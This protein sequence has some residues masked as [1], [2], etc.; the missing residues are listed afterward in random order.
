L[1]FQS[2]PLG[3]YSR[4]IPLRYLHHIPL[5]FVLSFQPDFALADCQFSGPSPSIS[6]APQGFFFKIPLF[7]P[8]NSL[9]QFSIPCPFGP[10]FYTPPRPFF[11]F[12][13]Q[14]CSY[15]PFCSPSAQA[16]VPLWRPLSTD[17]CPPFDK[18]RPLD[19]LPAWL[20]P[21]SIWEKRPVALLPVGPR[22][23][24]SFTTFSPTPRIRHYKTFFSQ[25]EWGVYASFHVLNRPFPFPFFLKLPPPTPFLIQTIVFRCECETLV[26]FFFFPLALPL[27][28]NHHFGSGPVVLFADVPFCSPCLKP[29]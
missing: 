28:S 22:P 1:G 5:F 9:C 2:L 21:P 14:T 7:S 4:H 23:L 8:P 24:D 26:F 13:L 20:W 11:F 19:L 27:K 29:F 25:W 18:R 16:I 15:L 12:F 10:R 6:R 3:V 17:S